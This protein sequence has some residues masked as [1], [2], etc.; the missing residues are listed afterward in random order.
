MNRN[1]RDQVA[2]MPAEMNLALTPDWTSAF[3]KFL[4]ITFFVVGVTVLMVV[5]TAVRWVFRRK[6]LMISAT[7]LLK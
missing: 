3:T 6:Q 7:L 5:E 4:F 1:E 2:K